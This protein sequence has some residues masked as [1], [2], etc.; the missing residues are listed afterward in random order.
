MSNQ[1]PEIIAKYEVLFA[2]RTGITILA[3][4][5]GIFEGGV[6]VPVFFSIDTMR[7]RNL[8]FK[9]GER[10]AILQNLQADFLDEVIT[11]GIL[12]FYETK[13]DEVIRCT[14]CTLQK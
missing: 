5:A 3:P 6:E 13:G 12:M 10:C 2:V 14:P 11:R 7:P 4:K 1:T 8:V 9:A